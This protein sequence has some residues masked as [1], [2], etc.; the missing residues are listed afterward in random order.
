MAVYTTIDDSGLFFNTI[1]YTGD[2]TTKTISGVGFQ[3]DM[4]WGK[5]RNSVSSHSLIDAVRGVTKSIFPDTG[6]IEDT[7]ATSYL[8]GFTAD[9][10]T[11]NS[12]SNFNVS[13]REQV[14]WNWKANGAGSSN[15]DGSINTISTSVSTTAGFSISTYTGTESADTVGHGLGAV[16]KVVIVKKL[17]QADDWFGYHEPLGNLARMQLSTTAAVASGSSYWNSTTPTS[18][19]FSLYNNGANN[20][21]GE[22][23]VAY[24]FANVRGFSS[25]GSYEGNAN[26]V[27]P[28]IYTGFRPA[29]VI[30]KRT[31]N[32][33][34]WV[35]YDNKR[36]GYNV[37]NDALNPDGDYVE[38][39]SD[40]LDLLSNGFKM[41][42]NYNDGN[43]GGDSYIYLAF[44]DAPFVNS[45]SVP[46]N[47]R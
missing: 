46:C 8:T 2:G 40:D 19:V 7:N 13:A 16:P 43:G 4:V 26:A 34:N 11:V 18:T 9:G 5:G 38:S 1:L 37:D 32:T 24:C 47:A 29:F 35:L 17:S 41:R 45:E 20:A 36:E 10:Y 14:N 27:G 15:E 31:N 33:A 44:A 42:R 3:P 12:A 28:F 6:A 39:T 21:V 23:L 25:F 22:T 30:C